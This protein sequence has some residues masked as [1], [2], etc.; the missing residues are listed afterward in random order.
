MLAG[1]RKTQLN[2]LKSPRQI[3][4]RYY[5]VKGKGKESS[6][7]EVVHT[8]SPDGQLPKVEEWRHLFP[9]A[10]VRGSQ[11]QYRPVLHNMDTA[12]KLV[13]GFGIEDATQPKVII[14]AFAGT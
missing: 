13:K 6:E 14:E 7:K 9:V 2:I 11:T 1:L 5:A 12:R 10:K 8:P 4:V 3:V